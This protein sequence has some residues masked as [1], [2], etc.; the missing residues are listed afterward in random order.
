MIISVKNKPASSLVAS[1]EKALYGSMAL[2]VGIV[3]SV[4]SGL[5]VVLYDGHDHKADGSA[6]TQAFL[7]CLWIS[8][9]TV[10]IPAWWNRTSSN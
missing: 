10:I 1:S 9:G 5:G 4:L 3:C 2:I 6:L 7:L 8:C